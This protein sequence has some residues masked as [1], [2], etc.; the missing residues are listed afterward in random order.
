MSLWECC[1]RKMSISQFPTQFFHCPLKWKHLV[2]HVWP[3]SLCHKTGTWFF[4]LMHCISTPRAPTNLAVPAHPPHLHRAQDPISAP[5]AISPCPS[6]TIEGGTLQLLIAKSWAPHCLGTSLSLASIQFPKA[7]ATPVT[8]G[9]QEGW[10]VAAGTCP[11]TPWGAAGPLCA[12][13][14]CCP[15]HFPNSHDHW[16]SPHSQNTHSFLC[17][18]VAGTLYRPH[19]Y[20]AAINILGFLLAL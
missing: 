17:S 4:H 9:W 6:D 7:G 5:Q 20:L 8:P 14:P 19:K 12:L 10:A 13:T 3:P 18:P 16:I 1:R 2:E 11:D 15:A